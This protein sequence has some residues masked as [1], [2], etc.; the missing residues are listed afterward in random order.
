MSSGLGSVPSGVGLYVMAAILGSCLRQRPRF[1]IDAP[2]RVDHVPG[3][4][5]SDQSFET[6]R[7]GRSFMATNSVRLKVLR[8]AVARGVAG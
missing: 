8:D 6:A 2:D 7:N 1:Q 5:V 4:Q 3:S